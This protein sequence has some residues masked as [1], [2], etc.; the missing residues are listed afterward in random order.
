MICKK[1]KQLQKKKKK[2]ITS[3]R[4]DVLKINIGKLGSVFGFWFFFFDMLKSLTGFSL[5]Y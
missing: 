3:P 5:I 2:E 4:L 1:S